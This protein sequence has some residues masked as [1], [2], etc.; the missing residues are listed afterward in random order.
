M[1]GKCPNDSALIRLFMNE[2]GPPEADWLLRH[3]ASCS[4]CTFRFDVLK[5]LNRELEP[6]V[7]A[8]V[9]EA[10]A[11]TAAE[12]SSALRRAASERTQAL[13]ASHTPS[14]SSS[15]SGFFG[16]LLSLKFAAGFL[17][18]LLVVSAVAYFALYKPQRQSEL[19]SPSLKLTLLAPVGTLSATPSIFRWT[20]VL[21]A[22]DYV[23]ELID[24]SLG[25]VHLGS[26]FL[27]TELVLPA[28]IRSK[29]VEGRVYVWSVSAHDADS[30]LLTSRSGSFVIE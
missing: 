13:R 5:Q 25:R 15:R 3:L 27:I 22:E 10:G 6:K 23:L 4:R 16:S 1:I 8:F 9:C 2:S 21:H 18:V 19:R 7:A 14:S 17:A 12:A 20:P 11:L 26:T 28:E 29:L 30:N 24:D